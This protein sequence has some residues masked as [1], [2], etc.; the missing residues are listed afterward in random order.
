MTTATAET[1]ASTEMT[2]LVAEMPAT[3]IR[4]REQDASPS[5]FS[6]PSR[7][8]RVM[9]PRPED[10]GVGSGVTARAQFTLNPSPNLNPKDGWNVDW[11]SS[12][13]SSDGWNV[14]WN[15][16]NPSSDGW[17]LDWMS[18]NSSSDGS[19]LDWNTSSDG[20]N[21]DWK[22]SNPSSDGWNVDWKSSKLL[23]LTVFGHAGE[24]DLLAL[25]L[26]RKYVY[27]STA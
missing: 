12:N 18:S 3:R 20:W 26:F 16:S 15:S 17:N 8:F 19:N 4:Q 6:P 23:R 13:P 25:G 11:K 24:R 14:D 2:E 7:M 22:S 27:W 21:L 5:G 1:S 9:S 10:V